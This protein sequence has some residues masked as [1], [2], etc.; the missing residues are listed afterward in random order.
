MFGLKI[1]SPFKRMY[2]EEGL[3]QNIRRSIM[4]MIFGNLFGNLFGTMTSGG[5]A[6][7][8]LAAKLGANDFIYGI[9]TAIPCIG[10]LMQI[11]AAILVSKTHKR[12]KYMLLY[13]MISRFVWILIGLVP[14]FVPA[15]PDWLRIWSLI[16]FVGINSTFG[17]FINVCWTPWMADLIP[18]GIRG[19][20]ISV[21]DR[22]ISVI[23]LTVGI[24]SAYV[25]DLIPGYPGYAIILG[26]GG[27]L[28]MMDMLCFIWVENV[29]MKTNSNAR[30]RD[31]FKKIFSDSEFVR[32]MLFWTIWCFTTNLAG[33]FYTRYALGDL[34]LTNTQVTIAGNV[35]SAII[36]MLIVPFWGRKLDTYGHKPIFWINGIIGSL[37]PLIW[38][39]AKPGDMAVMLIYNLVANAF[40]C[41]VNLASQTSLLSYATEEERPVYIA[42]YS[43]FTSLLGSFLGTFLGGALLQT[44][45]DNF[46][47][48]GIG[49]LGLTL[50]HYKIVFIISA[51]LRLI[52][53]LV[54]V[55]KIQNNRE[56]SSRHLVS[57]FFEG[58]RSLFS[59]G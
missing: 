13:G 1:N 32:F 39:F 45:Q 18:I 59:R 27:I 19:R 40:L 20:W 42:L 21:R 52:A 54:F 16:F 17:S 6:L 25:L 24:L 12:K 37:T 44:L 9:L 29:P 15:D 38:L 48:E 2:D 36:T 30:F 23:G 3:P 11:P 53:V 57:D 5:P 35:A 51:V 47:F 8:G 46:S 58:I 50:D 28:G 4:F 14:Y 7:T 10:T 22:I 34:S 31:I 43:C 56:Y 55:P 33:S 49:L 26:F 41:A